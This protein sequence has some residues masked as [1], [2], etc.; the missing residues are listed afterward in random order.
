MNPLLNLK[1]PKEKT[2]EAL[3]QLILQQV[4]EGVVAANKE[5]GYKACDLVYKVEI[6][7]NAT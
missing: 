4:N 6:Y 7:S 1:F 3:I 2:E 5:L